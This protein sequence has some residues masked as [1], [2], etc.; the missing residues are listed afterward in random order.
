MFAKA[1]PGLFYV[2]RLP[3]IDQ[4]SFSPAAIATSEKK[5]V[6]FS[7]D[8]GGVVEFYPSKRTVLR[9]D[10]GDTILHYNAQEP[11]EFNPSFVRHTFQLSTGFGFRF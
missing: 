9:L 8:I 10:V 3:V 4:L 11:K 6:F 5:A 7:M 1:R 2:E